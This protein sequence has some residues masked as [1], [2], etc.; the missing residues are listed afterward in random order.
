[1]NKLSRMVSISR[2]RAREGH[3]RVP[4][5]LAEMVL[6]RMLHGVGP[7]YYHMAGFWRRELTWADKTS[8]LSDKEYRRRVAVL[9]PV[10]YRKLSQNKIPEK[11]ILTL[12]GIPTARFLGRLNMHVGVDAVGRPL[13]NSSDL[14]RLAREQNSARLVF[15]PVEGWG[16]KGI[17]IPAIGLE[18]NVTFH[19][20]ANVNLYEADAYCRDMLELDQGSDWIIEEYFHQHPVLSA[21][22]P[23]S[24]NTIRIW[25]L[26]PR[27]PGEC[28][29]LLAFLRMGRGGMVVD[30][31]SSGGIAAPV[32]LLSGELGPA[33]DYTAEYTIYPEHPDHG[34][35]IRGVVLPYWAEAKQLA[36]QVLSVFPALRF[37]GLD[38]AIGASGPVIQELNVCPDHDNAAIADCPSS[39]LLSLD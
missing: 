19:E 10:Q 3:L 7:G 22:N 38:V 1:M 24:V 39:K 9:N 4:R 14:V 2:R 30:N 5:Q 31:G 27:G 35:P 23:T 15:K 33:R 34:A 16:G 18:E 13:R 28:Q 11:A 20:P 6:L 25:A 32:N 17:H 8:Q 36:C 29:V 21:L 26:A 12:F 37:A